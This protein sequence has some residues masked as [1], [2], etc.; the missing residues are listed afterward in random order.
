MIPQ[1]IHTLVN[2]ASP[3][4]EDFVSTG[5]HS[6]ANMSGWAVASMLITL[7]IIILFVTFIGYF[8]W[9]AVVA[10]AGKNDTGLFTCV[11][12]ADS[13]WQILGLFIVTSLF[14]GGCCPNG[15]GASG[16]QSTFL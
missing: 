6:V 12:R 9:N 3:A 10:G 2:C 14:F 1:T 16:N 7:I 11:K 8:L 13:M 4:R 15:A 5:G